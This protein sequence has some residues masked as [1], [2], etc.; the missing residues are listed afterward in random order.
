MFIWG[1]H[2]WFGGPEQVREAVGVIPDARLEAVDA[3]HAP[4]FGHP[5]TCAG[6]IREMRS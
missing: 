4:W 3:D 1:E 5:E 6:L 2:D